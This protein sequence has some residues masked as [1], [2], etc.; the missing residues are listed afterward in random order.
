MIY[1]LSA[2]REDAQQWCAFN[3]VAWRDVTYLGSAASCE[4]RRIYAV[5]RIVVT[6]RAWRHREYHQMREVMHR[7]AVKSGIDLEPLVT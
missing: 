1:I 4:G 2:S 6:E 3:D 7:N 5:D